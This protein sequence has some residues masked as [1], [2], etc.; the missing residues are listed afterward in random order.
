MNST[1]EAVLKNIPGGVVLLR[2]MNFP[3]VTVNNSSYGDS[4]LIVSDIDD[5]K[6]LEMIRQKP[7]IATLSLNFS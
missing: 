1:V 4:N 6:F 3:S 5:Y 2:K 7:S